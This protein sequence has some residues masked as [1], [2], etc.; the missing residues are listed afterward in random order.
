M[1]IEPYLTGIPREVGTDL[2]ITT[3]AFATNATTCGVY[4][5]VKSLE[6]KSLADDNINLTEEEYTNWGQDNTYIEDLVLEKL[7]LIRLVEEPEQLPA[8]EQE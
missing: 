7:G 3:L 2:F 1:K 5:Q 8:E 6:G 4:W